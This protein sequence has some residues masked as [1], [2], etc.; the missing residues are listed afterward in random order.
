MK[1]YSTP[2][3]QRIS[4]IESIIVCLITCLLLNACSPSQTKD[5]AQQTNTD[6]TQNLPSSKV[7]KQTEARIDELLNKMSIR[8][9]IGQLNLRGTSSRVK[10]SLPEELL[11]KVRNGEVGA[12]LNVMDTAHIRKL[13]TIA[14]KES[15]H[16]I[17]LI[18]ARDVIHGFKTI[19]PIPLGQAASWNPAI[20]EEGSRI[21][22]L[23]ASS[24]GI[25][26]TFAPMLDI[27]QD[28]R[29]GRIA[30]SPGE[31]PYLAQAM[32]S[33]YIK[34]F[35]GEN[36][37]D[38]TRIAACAKHFIGYGAAIGGRDYNTAI[39]SDELLHN[40]YLPPFEQ[41]VKNKVATFMT[42]FNEVNGVP[43]SGNKKI[44]TDI[45]RGKFKFGGF[46][47]SD[48]NS[49]TEM[50]A[51]GFAR[52]QKQAAELAAKAGMD[53][54]MT[55]RAYEKFLEILVKQGVVPETQLNFY[56]RNILRIKF[57]LNLFEKPFIPANHPGKFYA[58][59]HLAKAKEAAIESSVLLKN[60]DVLPLKPGTKILLTGPLAHKGREQL[61]TWTFDGEGDPSITPKEALPEATFVEGLSF[62]RDQSQD[63]FQQVLDAAR[64]VDVIVFVGGEEA[65]LSGEAHSRGNIKLP[66]A[67]EQ[68]L[69]ELTKLNKP[70]VLAIMAG[71]PINITNYLKDMQAVLMMWHPGTMGGPA[72]KEMLFGNA[73]PGGRLP[74][75]WPKAAGQLPYFYN[76]KN[77]GRPANPKKFVGIKDI[78]MG[79][80]Q[81][82]L[83][84]ESHYLDLGY[85][86]LFPFGYGLSYGKV[87]YGELK[88]SNTKL[89]KGKSINVTI[90]VTNTGTRN[91]TEVV[92]LYA[93]DKVGRITRP[94]RELK[95]FKKIKLASGKSQKIEFTLAYE[96]L[97]Y[98]DNEGKYALEPGEIILYV[99]SNAATKNKVVIM[100][101]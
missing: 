87:K 67:Q 1:S 75:S 71:R 21:A 3:P 101:E 23:E 31:D 55:S 33:A 17:P 14:V 19:F 90:E 78:P 96:D 29:W 59:A 8:E 70:I 12:F 18:F 95:R 35:Q 53:M 45:L 81:S 65:I 9:K 16:G 77:T 42:S 34:G 64:T 40:L 27:C 86:P 50:I 61:G 68:L 15:K 85:T 83:G 43:A 84:N 80:W 41:A 91:T 98:Y 82:S 11:N 58:P 37:S 6:H 7:D 73:E 5:T 36:L 76:H 56:V 10:G 4:Q 69:A 97:M 62:S 88:V 54:E 51:H 13:Q 93:Q 92:Q 72:L 38:P 94:V 63:N 100:I 24:V 46:V 30:E 57:R 44:L 25:R 89:S 32:A 49:V 60:N 74:V 26:W 2:I 99:G 39:I 22:A 52:D 66:G 47:V 79:A 48:W 28:S 20:V